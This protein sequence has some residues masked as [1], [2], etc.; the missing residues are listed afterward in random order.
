MVNFT[1]CVFCHDR[2]IAGKNQT[3][4]LKLAV[5]SLGKQGE[6]REG[7]WDPAWGGDGHY[8]SLG[9]D[10]GDTAK[11]ALYPQAGA[12]DTSLCPR[13]F[14]RQTG[15]SQKELTCMACVGS[16]AE[17]SREHVR[18]HLPSCQ[19]SLYLVKNLGK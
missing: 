7:G 19:W 13:S 4:P 18:R 11:P 10:R 1:S 6:S 12:G 14:H 15:Y 2:K 16:H 8:G 3:N 17:G 9:S 5:T